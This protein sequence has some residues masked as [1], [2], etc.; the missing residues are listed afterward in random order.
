[1]TSPGNKTPDLK[2]KDFGKA[3]EVGTAKAW[4]ESS[5]E[6]ES[7]RDNVVQSWFKTTPAVKEEE[8]EISEDDHR[9]EQN[10]VNKIDCQVFPLVF[11]F[12][13]FSDSTRP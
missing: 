6:D 8:E 5:I 7:S 2:A 12:L 9:E 1:M 13:P 10:L 4:W 3:P 11:P